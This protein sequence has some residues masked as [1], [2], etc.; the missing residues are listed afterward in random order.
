MDISLGRMRRG[1]VWCGVVAARGWSGTGL[2]CCDGF[3]GGCWR[4]MSFMLSWPRHGD[5][6]MAIL[7]RRCRGVNDRGGVRSA[8]HTIPSTAMPTR[9]PEQRYNSIP[10]LFTPPFS[11]PPPSPLLPQPAP[12][13][14]MVHTS[15]P[16]SPL[17][18]PSSR[19]PTRST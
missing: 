1:V 4:S 16:Y 8:V 2:A 10:S 12:P 5:L 11:V 19:P 17:L 15:P 6:S 13:G 18:Q 3:F 7:Q 9:R 14:S